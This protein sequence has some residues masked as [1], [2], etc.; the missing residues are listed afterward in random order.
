MFLCTRAPFVSNEIRAQYALPPNTFSIVPAFVRPRSRGY[1][2]LKTAEPSGPL[3]IQPNFLSERA[4]VDAL[5]AGI[6]LGFEIA[7]QPAFRELVKRLVVPPK[8]MSRGERVAFIRRSCSTYFHP[9]GTCAMGSGQDAV[10][11][12]ELR[13]RGVEGLRIADASVMPTIT[14]ANTQAP[15]VMIGEFASRQLVAGRVA[16]NESVRSLHDKPASIP[17][18]RPGALRDAG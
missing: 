13:V 8:R 18:S 9:V 7:S 14:S 15:V 16:T 10:V 11:D 2:R 1:L 3:E 4:D 17:V 6:E 12:A 5:V